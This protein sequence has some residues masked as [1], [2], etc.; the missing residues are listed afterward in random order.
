MTVPRYEPGKLMPAGPDPAR[1]AV[2]LISALAEIERRVDMAVR[3]ERAF[4]VANLAH[5]RAIAEPEAVAWLVEN[6]R[7]EAC[8]PLRIKKPAGRPYMLRNGR[9]RLTAARQ[10]GIETL[11]ALIF[12]EVPGPTEEETT[13]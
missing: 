3:Y 13:R 11:P 6:W 5:V 1:V 7:D 10:L 4:A 9:H 8:E 2:K 12:V